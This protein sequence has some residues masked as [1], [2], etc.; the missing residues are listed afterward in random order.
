[1]GG[2]IPLSLT[3]QENAVAYDHFSRLRSLLHLLHKQLKYPTQFIPFLPT[4]KP[5]G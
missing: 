4:G 1:M 2:T 3:T 5:V